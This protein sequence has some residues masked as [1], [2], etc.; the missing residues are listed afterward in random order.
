MQVEKSER[1]REKIRMDFVDISE[2]C[3]SSFLGSILLS[4]ASFY[5]HPK[6]FSHLFLCIAEL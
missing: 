6:A 5:K 2:N 4:D 1:R 3:Y